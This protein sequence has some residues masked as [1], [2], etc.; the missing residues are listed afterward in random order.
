MNLKKL[1]MLPAFSIFSILLIPGVLAHCPLCVVGAAAAAGGAMWLGVSKVV[2]GLFIGAFAMSM[3]MWI[4]RMIKKDYIPFQNSILIISIFLLTFFP[5][6]PIFSA[7][8]PFYISLAG[9]Y[10]TLLNQTYMVDYSLFSGLLGGLIVLISPRINKKIKDIRSGEGIPFQGILIAFSLL[11][12]SGTI[13]QL[14]I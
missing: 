8:G 6:M 5:M 3:G 4:A 1:L 2:V 14:V 7:M 11:L 10:G 9:G 13:I 12:I